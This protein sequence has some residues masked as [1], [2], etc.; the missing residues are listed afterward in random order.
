[1]LMNVMTV[2]N[3]FN[4]EGKMKLVNKLK[5]IW[6]KR[7]KKIYISGKISDLVNYKYY[8]SETE[9]KLRKLGYINIVNPVKLSEKLAKKLKTDVS[10]IDYDAFMCK[11]IEHLCRCN[12]IYLQP[13]WIISKGAIFEKHIA[14]S[15]KIKVVSRISE[16]I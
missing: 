16:L 13:N 1:M 11:D 8:F 3:K 6:N 12:I 2:K 14:E 4:K 5:N 10:L 9:K 15:L 7:H